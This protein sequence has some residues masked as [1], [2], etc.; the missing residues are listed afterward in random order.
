MPETETE[1][2]RERNKETAKASKATTNYSL[3]PDN[4]G[5]SV[6]SMAIRNICDV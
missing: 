5:P 6:V 3:A 2:E 1:R 4:A